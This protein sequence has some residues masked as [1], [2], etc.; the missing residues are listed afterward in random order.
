MKINYIEMNRKAMQRLVIVILL[1][2][3]FGFNSQSQTVR[4]SIVE[5]KSKVLSDSSSLFLKGNM[6]VKQDA[7]IDELLALYKKNKSQNSGFTGYRIQIY[8]ESSIDT[9]VEDAQ[10]F[11][12]NFMYR[13][14]SLKVYLNYYDPEFKIRVGNYHDKVEAEY[15]LQR[16]KKYYPNS[17]TVKC[18][19]SFAEIKIKTLQEIK[20]DSVANAAL[21]NEEI[22][23]NTNK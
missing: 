4:D 16:I 10:R 23:H 15:D 12:V 2:S 5:V 14:P 11:K 6:S 20:Q 19:I 3:Q 8:S 7:R 17:Y 18:F 9:S 21:M 22:N 1:L 13:Y